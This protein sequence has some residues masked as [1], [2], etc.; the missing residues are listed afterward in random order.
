M[1][2]A[3][4]DLKLFFYF[5]LKIDYLIWMGWQQHCSLFQGANNVIWRDHYDQDSQVKSTAGSNY[6]NHVIL[7]CKC[8]EFSKWTRSLLTS[9]CLFNSD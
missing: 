7:Q 3:P 8:F 1:D 9:G 6:D 2:T 4:E 5:Q